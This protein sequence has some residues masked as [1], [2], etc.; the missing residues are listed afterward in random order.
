MIILKE[1]DGEK[2]NCPATVGLGNRKKDLSCLGTLLFLQ[3]LWVLVW[4]SVLGLHFPSSDEYC[5]LF[6]AINWA[7]EPFFA[8]RDHI[9][10]GGN[11]WMLG[12]LVYLVGHTVWAGI[13]HG[14]L[15]AVVCTGAGWFFLRVMGF[16]RWVAFAGCV[17]WFTRPIALALSKSPQP[18]LLF[19]ACL[20]IVASGAVRHFQRQD[21][22]SWMMPSRWVVVAT[23]VAIFS[24]TLR[25]EG[26]FLSVPWGLFLLAAFIVTLVQ[27]RWM[28]AVQWCFL[29]IALGIFPLVWIWDA[30]R[31]LGNG[32]GFLDSIGGMLMYGTR[33]M[34]FETPLKRGLY[35]PYVTL[36]Q[37]PFLWPFILLALWRLGVKGKLSQRCGLAVLML[38]A[39]IVEVV[40]TLR[41]TGNNWEFRYVV[42]FLGPC[43]LLGGAVLAEEL[44]TRS[45]KSVLFVVFLGLLLAD[46][47]SCVYMGKTIVTN[48][49]DTDLRYV[50]VGNMLRALSPCHE[51]PTTL[52]L[53]EPKELGH[54]GFEYWV[55]FVHSDL[56]Y[57]VCICYQ[58]E[59]WKTAIGDRWGLYYVSPTEDLATP[60]FSFIPTGT[61]DLKLFLCNK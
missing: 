14:I 59:V 53:N 55:V 34:G 48:F 38:F 49:H 33:L 2:M 56:D 57:N 46:M 45:R 58:D 21:Q 10:V 4:L 51:E 23:L 54:W 11:I 27:R 24:Q 15:T 42:P 30:N 7:R 44:F 50:R 35:Y 9:W 32:L 17:L 13:I 18:M 6:Y 16:G 47:A 60:S 29:G 31:V 52:V 25:Y 61:G 28:A 26:W 1:K 3:V 19:V 43:M 40:V 22:S 39:L 12:G 41:G 37:V 5:R 8:P 36:M 20:L